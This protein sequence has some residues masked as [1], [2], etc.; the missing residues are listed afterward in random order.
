MRRPAPTCRSRPVMIELAATADLLRARIPDL[1]RQLA[2]RLPLGS[3]QSEVVGDLRFLLE[4]F[5]TGLELGSC[6]LVD[7]TLAWQKVRTR[8][9]GGDADALS[10]LHGV[11]AELLA[12]A[13]DAA[14]RDAVERL[15]DNA[16]TFVRFAPAEAA[17]GR[18][19]LLQPGGIGHEFLVAASA[20]DRLRAQAAARRAGDLPT[21]LRTVI[22]PAQREIG[23]LWQGGRLPPADEH[24]I[25][26]VVHHVVESLAAEM[27]PPPADAPLVAMVRAPGDEHALGQLCAS[28]HV[29]GAGFSTRIL[30]SPPR[31]EDLVARLRALAPAAIAITCTTALQARSVRGMVA[32]IRGEPTLA[33]CVVLLGGHLVLDVP[34]LPTQ[35]GADGGACDGPLLATMLRG[36]LARQQPAAV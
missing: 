31:F 33:R 7:R 1:A 27:P 36:L 16:A 24:V 19:P 9:L 29:R 4:I 14:Q 34:Q 30:A 32:A 3:P 8:A 17:T 5:A 28:A 25:T 21:A 2:A 6:G 20:G 12:P 11:V 35:L 13:L 22:E 10:R 23:R 15:L 18:D 26:Q